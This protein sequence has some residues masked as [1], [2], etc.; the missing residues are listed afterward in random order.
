[1]QHLEGLV[2]FDHVTQT[3]HPMT[4]CIHLTYSYMSS[5]GK[6]ALLCFTIFSTVSTAV[7]TTQKLHCNH[8]G[9]TQ[10][11][12]RNYTVTT[13]TYSVALCVN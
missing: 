5:G 8:K 2:G 7:G 6:A 1:M 9:T 4:V 3:L 12:H 13:L 11:H 10:G